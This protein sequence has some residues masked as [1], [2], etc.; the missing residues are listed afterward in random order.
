[1]H[2]TFSIGGIVQ[3][4]VEYTVDQETGMLRAGQLVLI[5]WGA[6]AILFRLAAVMIALSGGGMV[7]IRQGA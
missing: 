4:E 2:K 7:A 5:S 3:G 1:M 6:L